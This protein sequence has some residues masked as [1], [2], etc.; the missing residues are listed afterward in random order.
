MSVVALAVL[1][2]W[3]GLLGRDARIFAAIVI[4]GILGNALICGGISQPANRYGARVI[5]LLPFTAAFLTMIAV[6]SR[7]SEPAA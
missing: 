3:P 2:I 5:W 7:R 4:L 6:K 1:V